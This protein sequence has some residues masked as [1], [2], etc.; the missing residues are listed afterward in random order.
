MRLNDRV[1]DAIREAILSGALQP[2]ERLRQDILAREFGTS[3]TPVR[4]AL[5][6]L[7]SDGLVE[8]MPHRGA[9]VKSLSRRDIDEIYEVR[10]ALDPYAAEL[11]T[12]RATKAELAQIGKLAERCA[13]EQS[14]TARVRFEN[15]RLFHRSLYAPCGNKRLVETLDGLW[16]SFTAVR[17]FEAY[18]SHAR[19]TDEMNREHVEIAKA[20]AA[21]NRRQASV[22]VH[23]HVAAAR[24]ELRALIEEEGS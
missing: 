6:R 10:E 16:E 9:V 19:H 23:R 12:E 3:A 17:M 15:N 14:S 7:A 2:G 21:R 13:R 24:H 4:E 8:L 5:N 20:M 1:R 18:V 11:T 22:L